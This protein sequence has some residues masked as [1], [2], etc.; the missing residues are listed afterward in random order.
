MEN[1]FDMYCQM[2]IDTDMEKSRMID[3]VSNAVKG[4]VEYKTSYILINTDNIEFEFVENEDFEDSM[5]S[6]KENGFLYSRYYLDIEPKK[7]IDPDAY[8]SILSGLMITLRGLKCNVVAACDFE[9]L[10]PNNGHLNDVD[11]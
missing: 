5:R 7:D 4:I 11:L 6:D 10:L 2:F 9:D 8:I 3:M 1:S